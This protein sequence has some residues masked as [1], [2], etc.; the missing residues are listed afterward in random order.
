MV[1]KRHESPEM[2]GVYPSP[3]TSVVADYPI[4]FSSQGLLLELLPSFQKDLTTCA[5]KKSCGMFDVPHILK[6]PSRRLLAEPQPLVAETHYARYF[7]VYYGVILQFVYV[8]RHCFYAQDSLK[9][10]ERCFLV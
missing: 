6:C 8:I 3:G 4:N 10:A 2:F 1:P 9:F 7:P 5:P